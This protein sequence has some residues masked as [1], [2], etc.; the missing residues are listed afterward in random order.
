MISTQSTVTPTP[1]PTPAI[2]L[3]IDHRQE[4]VDRVL[5]VVNAAPSYAEL[6]AALAEALQ[7]IEDRLP[8]QRSA[9]FERFGRLES[10]CVRA[11]G[12]IK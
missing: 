6:T 11:K 10:L 7:V 8:G 1:T 12:A 3:S 9:A 2:A 4:I 5:S